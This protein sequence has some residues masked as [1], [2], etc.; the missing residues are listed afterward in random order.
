M[1]A[2]LISTLRKPAHGDRV[3]KDECMFSF[4]TPLTP[5]GIYLNLATFQAFSP[6]YLPLDQERTGGR[7]YLHITGKRVLKEHVPAD[8]DAAP[9][10]VTKF[11]IGVEGGFQT[12]DT[13]YT[14]ELSYEVAQ[15]PGPV[16]APYPSE[17]LPARLA[18]IVASVINY[19]DAGIEE[20][21][22]GWEDKPEVTRF[23]EAL[24]QLTDAPKVSPNPKDWVCG[25][26]DKTENLWLNLSDGF[27]GCGRKQLDG[28]GGNGHALAHFNETGRVYPLCVKLGTITPQ[29]GDVY[30]YDPSEDDVVQDPNLAQHLSALGIDMMVMEKTEKSMA[31]LNI[32]AN[33]SYE[34]SKILDNK[35]KPLVP[36][37]GPGFVGLTNLG[38]SCYM[39]S[40]L[41]VLFA[42]P[43]FSQRY[44]AK[45]NAIFAGAPPASA[46][47]VTTQFAKLAVGLLSSTYVHPP[48]AEGEKAEDDT[49]S[50]GRFKTLLGRGHAEFSTTKQQDALEYLQHILETIKR[51]ER[52]AR[53]AG[54]GIDVSKL[55]DFALEEKLVCQQSGK[56]RVKSTPLNSLSLTIPLSAATNLDAV[57][58]YEE[59]QAAKKAKTEDGAAKSDEEPVNH[60]V[61]FESVME[62]F[63][64]PEAIQGF[65]SPATGKP[66]VAIKSF[67][68][69]TFPRYLILSLR[70]YILGDNWRPVKLDA[71]VGVPEVLDLEG[72]RGVGVLPGEEVLEDGGAPPASSAPVPDPDIVAALTAM[73]FSSNAAKRAAIAVSNSGAEAAMEW[74]FAHMGD[75]DFN[76]PLPAAA[77][78]A[79]PAYTADPEAVATC[80][81]M[82]FD[83]AAATLAL[84][85][86]GGAVDRAVDWLFSRTPAEIDA[87]LAAPA[88]DAAAAPAAV[89]DGPGVYD[90]VGF[91]SHMGKSTGSGHYVCHIKKDGEWTLFNDSKVAFS[92]APPL[93][94]GYVY[95]YRRRT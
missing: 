12:E 24:P 4:A 10:P 21:V 60:I 56:V 25:S 7:V 74:V 53:D 81:S 44:F 71:L 5:G 47:D 51:T 30:S 91:I 70:R 58:A 37:K 93:D 83:S 42:L 94:M 9:A 14:T 26:C 39:N 63:A 46:D 61:P 32:E 29:G 45:A 92:E 8:P 34:W 38:N 64:A 20:A 52:T 40:V 50:P 13:K 67:R 31:E 78:A 6:E 62:A 18:E 54:A 86:T 89:E 2:S 49:I 68:F 17:S 76:D 59:A 79:A 84:K 75:A 85:E 16:T 28:S 3:Y 66:G 65:R 95:I 48:P 43:E 27:I 90:I 73:D 72:L 69:A 1:D 15:F 87:L 22:S 82:G 41:Q 11:A 57:A 36:R 23:F 77:P 35:G 80:M 88:P 19:T 33:L 55:F